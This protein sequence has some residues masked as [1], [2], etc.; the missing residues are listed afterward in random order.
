MSMPNRSRITRCYPFAVLLVAWA[1]T[2]SGQSTW[3]VT[4]NDGATAYFAD[5]KMRMVDTEGRG[6]TVI[7]DF[8]K[9]EIT[10][11][12]EE[13]KTYM[14]GSFDEF[15][16]LMKKLWARVSEAMGSMGFDEKE[17]KPPVV[18]FK[19][20][21]QMGMIAGYESEKYY[22]YADGSMYEEVWISH[23]PSLK[24]LIAIMK[25]YVKYADDIRRCAGGDSDAVEDS[26]EYA[27]LYSKGWIMKSMSRTEEVESAPNEVVSI[28]KK[29]YSPA[30]FQPPK[31]YTKKPF[32]LPDMTGEN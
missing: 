26:P 10:V 9:R 27:Q 29:K 31:G 17:S 28:E 19:A 18:T 4:D 8:K 21:G 25:D 7:Y 23:D 24:N 5:G 20:T 14:R 1:T 3:T 12:D 11:I 22:V 16:E 15:C 13:S 32:E 6:E 2:A 30:D